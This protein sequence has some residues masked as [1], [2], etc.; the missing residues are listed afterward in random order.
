MNQLNN[1]RSHNANSREFALCYERHPESMRTVPWLRP[2]G[3]V[4]DPRNPRNEF[5]I[6]SYKVQIRSEK[7]LFFT[8][9]RK[10]TNKK[11]TFGEVG[12]HFFISNLL[13]K[14]EN[15]QKMIQMA[16]LLIKK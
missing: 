13:K 1:Q 3:R 15:I 9:N 8:P 10:I 12:D 6:D 11:M 16:R 5:Q 4:P 14:I 2:A 7:S